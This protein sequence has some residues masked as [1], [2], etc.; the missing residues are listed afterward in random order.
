MT[1]RTKREYLHE[2]LCSILGSRNCY[3]QSPTGLKMK[4]P[5]IKYD[6]NDEN[7]KYADDIIYS[8]YY[9]WNL[10][11]IDYDPESDIPDKLE[12]S[13]SYCSFDRSYFADGLAHF[14]LTL[15]F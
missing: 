8:K 5:C 7:T 14:V 9:R 6:L 1:M 10:T 12:E 15:Y 11:V 13:L 4:Y 2:R 3:F